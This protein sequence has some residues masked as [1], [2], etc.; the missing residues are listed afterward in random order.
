M[1][2]GVE[3]KGRKEFLLHTREALD[4]L[5]TTPHFSAIQR[6][7]P[8]IQEGKR[9]GMKADAERPTYVVGK[10]TWRHSAL[11]YAGTIAHDAY[12]S[13]LYHE[14]KATTDGKKPDRDT[15]TGAAAEKKCLAFQIQV[16]KELKADD[17]MIAYVEGWQNNPTY[18]GHHRGW[19]S[20]RDYLRRWW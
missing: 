3:I 10:S 19:R 7:V 17:S 14:A 12:H 20:W 11:W 9:S 4:L 15:W 6:Y 8:V 16:L 13:K 5:R 2:D 1:V 18:Q